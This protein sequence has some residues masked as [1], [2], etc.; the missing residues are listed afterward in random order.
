MLVRNRISQTKEEDFEGNM[1]LLVKDFRGWLKTDWLGAGGIG[2]FALLSWLAGRLWISPYYGAPRWAQVQA[3]LAA[4]TFLMLCC[5]VIPEANEQRAKIANYVTN[6][7]DNES[8]VTVSRPG[9]TE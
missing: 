4:A 3:V 5:K 1:Q 8:I 2:V 9:K 6:L 7:P